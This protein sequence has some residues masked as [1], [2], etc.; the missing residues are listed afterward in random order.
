MNQ[1][2]Q[3]FVADSSGRSVVIFTEYGEHVTTIF[4]EKLVGRGLGTPPGSK[5]ASL[6]GE[7][8]NNNNNSK[9]SS[10]LQSNNNSSN[11]GAVRKLLEEISVPPQA[12]GVTVTDENLMVITDYANDC[13]YYM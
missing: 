2:N 6:V 5:N 7:N 12:M 11:S 10:A 9:H 4:L 13:L 3:I 8:N 1:Q